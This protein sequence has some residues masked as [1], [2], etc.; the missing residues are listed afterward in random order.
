LGTIF[1]APTVAQLAERIETLLWA[2]RQFQEPAS[3]NTSDA[4]VEL[5]L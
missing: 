4:H 2:A 3:I 1:E 5:E